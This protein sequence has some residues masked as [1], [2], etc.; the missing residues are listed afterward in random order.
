M[1]SHKP[2]F[3]PRLENVR[4]LGRVEIDE[5]R[6]PS[7]VGLEG[8]IAG[9]DGEFLAQ[10][11]EFVPGFHSGNC[12]RIALCPSLME[13]RHFALELLGGVVALFRLLVGVGGIRPGIVGEVF[14]VKGSGV[15]FVSVVGDIGVKPIRVEEGDTALSSAH[16][17]VVENGS[18]RAREFVLNLVAAGFVLEKDGAMQVRRRCRLIGMFE[19]EGPLLAVG[20]EKLH[21]RR[22]IRVTPPIAGAKGDRKR[23]SSTGGHGDTLESEKCGFPEKRDPGTGDVTK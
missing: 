23:S 21:E 19:V 16:L 17:V 2:C 13:K 5:F 4:G 9:R 18:K 3:T 22:V 12:D 11:H 20:V 8:G 1:T 6:E 15:R 10:Y 14:L 7:Q